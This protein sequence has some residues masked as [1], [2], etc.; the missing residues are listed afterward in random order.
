VSR[1][2]NQP[3]YDRYADVY[4]N[5]YAPFT[6]ETY[7]VG[8][9]GAHL[10]RA[11]QPAG[12]WSDAPSADLVV[13]QLLTKPVAAT[14]DLGGGSFRGVI[15]HHSFILI[16]P[17]FATTILVDGDHGI[18]VL[19]LPYARLRALTAG[20]GADLLPED[21]DFGRLHAG[22]LSDDR[23]SWILA[24]LWHEARAGS[25][26]GALAADGLLLQVAAGLLR[27]R[28]GQAQTALARGGLAPWRLHRCLDY[29][30]AHLAD[31]VSLDAMAS[32]AGL[33]PIYFAR[34]F[35]RSTGLAPHQYLI[36]ARLERAKGLLAGTE[37][38][39]A[40]VAL[41]CGFRDQDH[42]TRLFRKATGATPAVF[43]RA[44]RG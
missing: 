10:I 44:R 5:A 18:E 29:L 39:I 35:K 1:A 12:D 11:D 3:V 17:G 26:Q 7:S 34:L 33:S 31:D 40:R 37:Q 2:R 36:G 6:R 8:L 19:A 28:D 21:G 43:R 32:A 30:H 24:Q 23:F 13:T 4:A 41:D 14:M 25:S 27:M 38:P 9:T 15:P 20:L 42:L 16:P 22:C